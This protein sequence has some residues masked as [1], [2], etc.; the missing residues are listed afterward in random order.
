MCVKIACHVEVDAMSLS[1][2]VAI[3]ALPTTRGLNLGLETLSVFFAY[4]KQSNKE[5]FKHV[6]KIKDNPVILIIYIL[7]CSKAMMRF[8]LRAASSLIWGM[9]VC[10]SIL[11]SSRL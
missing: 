2:W 5:F 6:S 3:F 4:S 10:C 11:F 7:Y 9:R 8:D 1:S